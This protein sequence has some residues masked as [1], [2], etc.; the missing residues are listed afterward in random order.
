MKRHYCWCTTGINTWPTSIKMRKLFSESN[1]F[2][3][4][5]LQSLT[6]TLVRLTFQQLN[7]FMTEADII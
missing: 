1:I 5:F 4:T 2:A 3:N 6:F 7:P